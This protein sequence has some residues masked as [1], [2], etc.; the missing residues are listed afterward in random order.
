MFASPVELFETVYGGM[1]YPIAVVEQES[2][3]VTYIN[4]TLRNLSGVERGIKVGQIL[5]TALK[6]ASGDI[7]ESALFHKVSTETNPL[8]CHCLINLGVTF[9]LHLKPVQLDSEHFFVLQFDNIAMPTSNDKVCNDR[10]AFAMNEACDGLWDWNIKTN[11]VYFSP[12]LDRMLGFEPGEREPDVNGWLSLVHP[13]DQPVALSAIEKHLQGDAEYYEAEYRIATKDGQWKQVHDRGLSCEWNNEGKPTRAVGMLSDITAYRSLEAELRNTLERFEDYASSGSDWFW[14]TNANLVVT[15]IGGRPE[16]ESSIHLAQLIDQNLIHTLR[17]QEQTEAVLALRNNQPIRNIRFAIGTQEYWVNLSGR[18]VFD[19]QGQLTGYR[20]IGENINEQVKLENTVRSYQKNSEIMMEKAPVAIGI[21]DEAGN[22]FYANESFT[23]LNKCNYEQLAAKYQENRELSR[24]DRELFRSAALG[25]HTSYEMVL[26]TLDGPKFFSVT[27]FLTRRAE[28]QCLL[29]ITMIMDITYSRQQ[30]VEQKKVEMVLDNIAE[31]ILITDADHRI[32]SA[33]NSL[34]RETGFTMTE[35]VGQ[36]PSV[37]SSGRYDRIF[38][39]EMWSQVHQTGKWRGHLWNRKKDGTVLRQKVSIQA[40]TVNDDVQHY[41]GIYS[42]SQ[43]STSEQDSEMFNLQC[44]PLTGLPN[45][46]LLQD[47]L[48]MACQRGRA[49]RQSVEVSLIKI[50]NREE[51]LEQFGHTACDEVLKKL[52]FRFQDC[53]S[54]DDSIGRYGVDEFIVI[55]ERNL[56]TK[57]TDILGNITEQQIILS[58][59]GQVTVKIGLHSASYPKDAHSPQ[60]IIRQLRSKTTE[61]K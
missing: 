6:T 28:D 22:F 9:S 30:E 17:E 56:E 31:G 25:E 42:S 37:L 53:L 57:I 10:L 49:S 27:K 5:D 50:S 12:K 47:R 21:V 3:K 40:I 26:E 23:A 43:Q 7:V 11:A 1:I 29:A 52:A 38:Y 19:Q 36:T 46:A 33:N 60:K 55:R 35:L 48:H 13:D 24:P 2:L 58:D 20:G 61:L 16:H 15:D 14:E 4:T 39:Q 41:I 51:L 18:P 34:L 8:D 45:R 32:V 44:D 59:G 54:L